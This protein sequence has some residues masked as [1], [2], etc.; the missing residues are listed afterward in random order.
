MLKENKN[1]QVKIYELAEDFSVILM[2]ENVNR[3]YNWTLYYDEEKPDENNIIEGIQ[4][5]ECCCD[6]NKELTFD[7]ALEYLMDVTR[8]ID[9]HFDRIVEDEE[10]DDPWED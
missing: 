5:V 8:F 3:A 4:Y 1:K 10:Y 6:T 9:V 7:T 2:R